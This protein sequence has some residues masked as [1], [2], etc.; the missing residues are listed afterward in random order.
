MAEESSLCPN[1]FQLFCKYLSLFL[2]A[3]EMNNLRF[4]DYTIDPLSRQL[5]RGQE[6]ILLAPKVFDLLLFLV[7]NPRRLLLKSDLLEGV[8]PDSFVEESNLNQNISLLR[9][10]LGADGERLIVTLPRRGYQFTG[11][12]TEVPPAQTAPEGAAWQ[13]GSTVQIVEERLVY[14]EEREE[15]ILIR[16]SPGLILAIA[17]AALAFGAVAWLVWQR[18]EDRT[19]GPPVQVVVTTFEGSSGDPVL[20]QALNSALRAD[21]A[22]SPYVTVLPT[23][24]V[25]KTLELMALSA[26]S[27]LT[28]SIAHDVCERT[29]SQAVLRETVA[30]AGSRYLLTGEAVGCLDGATIATVT[31]TAKNRDDLPEAIERLGKGLRLAVGESRRTIA[32]FSKPLLNDIQTGSIEALEDWSQASSLSQVGKF[33]AA[34]EL[35]KHAV[36][37][38]PQFAAAWLDM[39][40]YA[41]ANGDLTTGR[42]YLKHAH[43]E[44]GHATASTRFIIEARY[45]SEVVGDLQGAERTYEAM[46]ALYPRS[47][48]AL[49]A[50]GETQRQLGHHADSAATLGRAL[51]LQPTYTTLFYGVCAEQMRSGHLDEARKTC[52]DGIRHGLDG[53]AIRVTLLKL[54]V[55]QHDSALRN[56]Q[57]VWGEQHRSS[58]LSIGQSQIDMAEG[59]EKDAVTHL[60]HACALL[61]QKPSDSR[62]GNVYMGVA[63]GLSEVGEVDT[64]RGLLAQVVPDPTDVNCILAFVDTGNLPKA[65]SLLATQSAS[66]PARGFWNYGFGTL[67]RADILLKQDKANEAVAVLEPARMYEGTTLISI[68]LRGIAYQKSG[69]LSLAEKEFTRLLAEPWIDPVATEIP[70]AQVAL[71]ETLAAENKRELALQAYQTFF[72]NWANADPKMKLLERARGGASKLQ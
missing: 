29:G 48:T 31:Q 71:A 23:A 28:P 30:Q 21:L 49:S 15:R 10:A 13:P 14:T 32:R 35:L 11:E 64:A 18:Y 54:S 60:A 55:V 70:L 39:S 63:A 33:S 3:N 41:A 19:G 36:A 43:A 46:L 66:Q 47:A 58:L 4:G 24:V 61:Q 44:R 9:K 38:D 26:D 62:C 20:D 12:V 37:I 17:V 34:I 27:R 7:V 52:E 25:R 5:W 22:Q 40:S 67:V 45:A 16:R 50:L 53:D 57:I 59:R 6:P 2:M 1:E 51:A 65:E 42:E 72:E 8:W 68:Y 69:Q 56:E